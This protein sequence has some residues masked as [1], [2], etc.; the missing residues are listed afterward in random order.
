MSAGAEQP[1]LLFRLAAKHGKSFPLNWGRGNDQK[2]V[3]TGFGK[4][5][6]RKESFLWLQESISLPQR[7]PLPPAWACPS[8]NMRRHHLDPLS[9]N[10]APGSFWCRDPLCGYPNVPYIQQT[11][12]KHLLSS[13]MSDDQELPVLLPWSGKGPFYS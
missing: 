5:R 3:F 4:G 9:A 13:L 11:C 12:I 2:D 6:S 10:R 1:L 8:H 7:V